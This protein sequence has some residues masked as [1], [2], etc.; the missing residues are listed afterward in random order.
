MKRSANHIIIAVITLNLV[1]F[2]FSRPVPASQT[3]D[4]VFR[5]TFKTMNTT[6]ELSGV[7]EL[8]Y[9]GF[10]KIYDGALYL[11]AEADSSQVLENIPKRLEVRYVRSFK[12]KDF[13]PATIAGIKKN[14]DPETYA[15]LESRIAYHNG[16]YDDIEPG[17][18]VSLT[19]IPAVGTQLEINGTTKGTIEGADFARAL[20]SIWL[21]EKPFDRG[22]K[23]A[24]LGEK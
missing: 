4:K 23:K 11:P 8:R 1:L 13:G 15:R 7:G 6:L 12:S 5:P 20:F 22:F 9:L 14:V 3:V 24:L 2:F 10:V 19:Y 16:L 18:R 21:G 17:D